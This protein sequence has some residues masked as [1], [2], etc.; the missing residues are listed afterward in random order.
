[1]IGDHERG[2]ARQLRLD[3]R[4]SQRRSGRPVR[5]AVRT[6]RSFRHGNE[7]RRHECQLS[8]V[9]NTRNRDARHGSGGIRRY[10]FDRRPTSNPTRGP[11]PRRHYGY[12]MSPRSSAVARA[13][14]RCADL[15]RPAAQPRLGCGLHHARVSAMSLSQI[16]AHKRRLHRERSRALRRSRRSPRRSPRR[17]RPRTRP[18]SRCPT[19][20]RRS[21]TW[22]T[23]PGSSRRSCSRAARPGYATFDPRSATCSTRTTRRSAPGIRAPS[24]GCCRGPASTRS[25]RYR[26]HVDAAMLARD[27]RP[28]A[29][30]R[31]TSSS[32][33]CTTSSS[34]RSCCSRTSSTSSRRTRSD[35]PT[36]RM[37]AAR[38]AST[39]G[40]SQWIEH[41]GGLVEIGH[42]RAPGSRSTTRR[43][44]TASSSSRYALADRPVTV[45][46]LARVHRRRRLRAA[47]A[48]A[49]RRLG[50]RAGARAGTRRC[51]GNADGDDGWQV[52]TLAR[53]A[54]ARPGRAGVPRQL[55][56][57]RRVRPL[58][59]CPAADRGRV[60]E[61]GRPTTSTGGRLISTSPCCIRA[62][63]DGAPLFGDVWEWTASAY[64]PYPRLPARAGR[65]RRVQRQVHG[66]P[67]RVARRL[68]RDAAGPRPRVTYRNF[69]PPA[70]RW[71]FSG[72]RLARDA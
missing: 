15:V 6:R 37:R 63:T 31:S 24:A 30:A 52:F 19:S 34:T 23:R 42:D 58:G 59:R 32:S 48:L 33:G 35:R 60:G 41:D 50:R 61:R 49:V 26:G 53:P 38:R 69:F 47:R 8:R 29:G 39:T 20:A 13:A 36:E 2:E 25:R 3:V 44:A 65:G 56:R 64:L 12:V 27:R 66:E 14:S 18:S 11:E 40:P 21:G 54:A 62:P 10:P 55:L 22:R 51:T 5:P 57:G 46:R 28:A 70:A 7:V 71:A 72:A 9:N 4:V 1:M 68:L 17:F 67:A 45:R 16:V 43:R